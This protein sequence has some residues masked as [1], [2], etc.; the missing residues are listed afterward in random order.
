MLDR[1]CIL[2]EIDIF[3]VTSISVQFRSVTQSCPTLCDPKDCSMPGLPVHHDSQSLLKLISIESVMPCNHL[4]LC[5]PLHLPRS[6]LVSIWVF[7]SESV[8]RIRWP[9]YWS[10]SFNISSS[11]E[12]SVLIS[13]RMNWIPLQSKGLSRVFSNITA[14]KHQFFCPQLSL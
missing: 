7:S 9:K 14:Q 11:N 6:I 5:H 2:L 1:D 10:F 4:T 3:S 13:F 12:H 8:L